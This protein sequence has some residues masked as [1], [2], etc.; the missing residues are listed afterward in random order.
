MK[1]EMI[2]ATKDEK[3]L[4]ELKENFQKEQAII[5]V[6]KSIETKVIDGRKLSFYY[7]LSP[8][9]QK[10]LDWYHKIRNFSLSSTTSPIRNTSLNGQ[11]V[12]KIGN[13]VYY[14]TRIAGS[15]RRRWCRWITKPKPASP[16]KAPQGTPQQ[17]V[18]QAAE[19]VELKKEDAKV[20]KLQ[21]K[22]YDLRARNCV[23]I[24][25]KPIVDRTSSVSTEMTIEKQDD[26]KRA[27][28][29]MTTEIQKFDTCD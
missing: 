12:R 22:L 21:K 17:P 11:I 4:A 5:T 10:A 6:S 14:C 23:E 8:N 2:K 3:C 27:N 9:Q 29:W 1:I 19:P 26:I 24:Q 25:Y 16:P 15:T 20:A 13:R 7:T 28:N 18:T